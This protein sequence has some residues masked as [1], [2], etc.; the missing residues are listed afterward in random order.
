MAAL[1]ERQLSHASHDQRERPPAVPRKQMTHKS[2]SLETSASSHRTGW[3]S[4]WH[5]CHRTGRSGCDGLRRCSG[6]RRPPHGMCTESSVI[7]SR[8]AASVALR[9][10]CVIIR[11]LRRRRLRTS[12][13]CTMLVPALPLG[14]RAA[15]ARLPGRRARYPNSRPLV[16]CSQVNGAHRHA[17]P[18]VLFVD[19]DRTPEGDPVPL[20]GVTH[21][22]PI[23]HVHAVIMQRDVESA[24][25]IG[26]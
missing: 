25:H 5:D 21:A 17:P 16:S 8:R 6:P 19:Q 3:S 10:C 20:T 22:A 18:L 14:H 15:V 24:G 13:T 11:H 7:R 1:T 4:S 9:G 26:H 23:T 2:R 12:T